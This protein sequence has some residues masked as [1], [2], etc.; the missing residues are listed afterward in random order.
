MVTIETV[1]IAT[2]IQFQVYVLGYTGTLTPNGTKYPV[3]LITGVFE[4]SLSSQL[5][6]TKV[7]LHRT[8][9]HQAHI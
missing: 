9:I 6:L 4:K 7:T 5:E 8:V 3:T 1:V 2:V